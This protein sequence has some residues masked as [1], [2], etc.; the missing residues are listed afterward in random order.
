MFRQVS[1]TSKKMAKLF[2]TIENKFLKKVEKSEAELNRFICENWN[3]LFPKF[4]FIASE[5]SLDGNVRA[6]GTG[7]RI[8]I[9]AY[10]PKNKRFIVVE[11]KKEFDKNITEQAADYRDFVEEKF[12]DI[13]LFSTQKYKV[14]LPDFFEI[15]KQSVEMVLVAKEF[16]AAQ[17][18]KAKRSK[19]S[20]ITLIKYFWFENGLIFIDYINN[21]PEEESAKKIVRKING[22]TSQDPNVREIESYFSTHEELSKNLGMTFYEFL[23]SKGSVSVKAY[24]T[25][26]SYQIGTHTF[27][28]IGYSGRVGRKCFLQINTDIDVT[29]IPDMITDDRV[30]ET[31]KKKG[32][33]GNERYE[34]F[35]QN[36]S[37]MQRLVSFLD[38]KIQV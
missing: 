8:D 36:D 4:T 2:S 13:Y 37:Q 1:K 17:I 26:L 38:D 15:Q 10:N 9:L 12:A 3:V 19:D 28:A 31:G 27:S 7:G 34:V 21:N 14:V 24:R 16:S 18:E 22:L 32:S 23:K 29:N 30:R 25:K 6:R 35:I 33:L 20:A 5:F 11:L